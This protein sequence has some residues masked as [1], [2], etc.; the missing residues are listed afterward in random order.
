MICKVL[1]LPACGPFRV[2][3]SYYASDRACRWIPW[4]PMP[5]G[6]RTWFASAGGFAIAITDV[7]GQRAL[8]THGWKRLS[9][10]A[11][12]RGGPTVWERE[13]Q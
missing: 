10:R 1:S 12:G 3:L 13:E 9:G 2:V 7:R 6:G 11:D 5:Y 8:P 4:T